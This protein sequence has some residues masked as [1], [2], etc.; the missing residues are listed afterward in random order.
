MTTALW[1]I[2]IGSLALSVWFLL[3]AWA[4]RDYFDQVGYAFAWLCCALVAFFALALLQL[5]PP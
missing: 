3:S 2:L 1:I 5:L 4:A